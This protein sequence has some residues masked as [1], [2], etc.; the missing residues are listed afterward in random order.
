MD[1]RLA[2]YFYTTLYLITLHE[3]SSFGTIVAKPIKT[4]SYETI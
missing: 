4:L 2:K 3:G 1:S